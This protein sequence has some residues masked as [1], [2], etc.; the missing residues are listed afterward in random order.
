[1]PYRTITTPQYE[2]SVRKITK[3]NPEILRRIMKLTEILKIDPY[4]QTKR[5]DIKKLEGIKPD[6]GQWRIRS[7]DY[8]IRYDIFSE[9][10]VLYL[11]SDRKGA[12]R[13]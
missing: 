1:M 9:D 12:Y 2:R 13:K 4:N 5:Y 10:V 3:R 6:E 7:G 8:R 11:A